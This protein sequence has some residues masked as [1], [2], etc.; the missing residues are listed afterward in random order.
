MRGAITV[1]TALAVCTL[2]GSV[3]CPGAEGDLVSSVLAAKSAEERAILL[4]GHDPRELASA[5]EGIAKSADN[6]YAAKDYPA[7]L[8]A[9]ETALDLARQTGAAG[10]APFYFRRLGISHALLGQNDA[11]LAAYS[12]GISA[13]EAAHDDAMLAENLHGEA[14]ILQ[15]IGRYREALPFCEREYALTEKVGKVEDMVRALNTYAQTLGEL[16]RVREALPLQSRALE[17]SRR[18]SR[19]D[20]YALNLGNF[21]MYYAQLGDCETALRLLEPL[22]ASN[23]N[24]QDAIAR[25]EAEL[26]RPVEAETAYRAAIANSTTPAFWRV[27]TVVLGNFARFQHRQAKLAAARASAEEALALALNHNDRG[28]AAVELA[29]LSQ[30]AVDEKNPAAALEK[31][32]QALPM[33]RESGSPEIIGQA[34]VAQGR[35]L[36]LAGRAEE[37]RHTFLEAVSLAEGQRADAPA[38]AAGLQGEIEGWM[39]AY[40][41]A[42]AHEIHAG[43]ALDALRLS[44]RAKARVLLDMLDGGEPG[45]DA[46]ADPQERVE[47]QQARD[48]VSGARVA[49]I[50]RPTPA[51][52]A[53]LEAALRKEDEFNLRLYA[54]HPELVLQRTA[55]P[56]IQPDDL[57]ALTSDR[58]TA[59][60]SYFLLPDAVT[61]FV[62]RAGEN[63][64]SVKVF[65]LA[66]G[67]KLDALIRS[68]RTQIA[69]RDL[70]YRVSARALFDALL[71]PAANALRGAD[72]W[73]LSPDGALWDVPF[74]AL[75][76][77]QGKHLIETHSV[78]YAPS[79]SVLRQLRVKPAAPR[80]PRTALLAVANPAVKG[81]APIPESEREANTI[82]ALYGSGR[83]TVLAGERASAGL[84]RAG[85]GEAAIIHIAS[86]A[87]TESNHPLESFLVFAPDKQNADGSLTARDL[88]GLHL[89][90]DL[91]VLSACET[92]RG[93]IGDGDGVMG[94]GWAALAAG[95]RAS[96]L[97]QWKV[98]SAA[99]SDLMIDFHRRLIAR[100]DKA[101]SMRQA[102]LDTM[103]SPGRAHPFYWA[104]FI[105]LGDAR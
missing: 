20:D 100:N 36:E 59:L 73:I 29:E 75:I 26:H 55:P 72:R 65:T 49:A 30:I 38:S 31:A 46:I 54:R 5:L 79:L 12:D 27:H 4:R 37:A 41:Y 39:P 83:A 52:K 95:A 82:A 77:A 42:V 104:G 8:H 53:A 48:E 78:S 71:A 51:S 6:F 105:V 33:A 28:E 74:Q 62:V 21:A 91:V 69:T 94:L 24:D 14:N 11:A 44:D 103:R 57:T 87:E 22:P 67:D 86:H 16:G 17:L 92:A 56:D 84:F 81:I 60:L 80:P 35:A 89:R 15:R 10:K 63:G 66:G 2:A 1:I 64:P 101:D 18:S 9:Y 34:L 70:D 25:C 13:A 97:S 40:Q 61:L 19:P 102:A 45:F 3:L 32:A 47:E 90:A 93:R 43:N 58:R 23:P 99:T 98:D 7:A 50:S 96:V 85:A 68:F 76:D 88:L